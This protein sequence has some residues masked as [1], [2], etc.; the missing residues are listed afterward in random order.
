MP[1]EMLV[2]YPET[3]P[4]FV[5]VDR[6]GRMGGSGRWVR[7]R[8]A[9]GVIERVVLNGESLRERPVYDAD[10]T[11]PKLVVFLAARKGPSPEQQQ[12]AAQRVESG[13]LEAGSSPAGVGQV[14]RQ[15]HRNRSRPARL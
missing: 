2:E 13:A 7:H 6:L 8:E 3:D 10:Q 9:E 15:T 1:S 5:G 11:L 12:L 14:G 4:I